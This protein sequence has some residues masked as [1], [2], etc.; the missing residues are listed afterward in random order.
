MYRRRPMCGYYLGCLQRPL[1]AVLVE[2]LP[3]IRLCLE[4][5]G[6]SPGVIGFWA[7]CDVLPGTAGKGNKRFERDAVGRPVFWRGDFEPRQIHLLIMQCC[8]F[9]RAVRKRRSTGSTNKS[10]QKQDSC[11][12]GIRLHDAQEIQSDAACR[13]A[14]IS[15]IA[16]LTASN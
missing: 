14:W 1:A 16:A 5:C 6:G 7:L 3:V 9:Y 10:Q 8:S 2:E 15:S 13:L 4:P 12:E 11:G